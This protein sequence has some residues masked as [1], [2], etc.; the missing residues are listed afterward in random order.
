MSAIKPYVCAGSILSLPAW[1]TVFL[2]SP[3]TSLEVVLGSFA[4]VANWQHF[5]AM[6]SFMTRNPKARLG[7]Q[8]LASR[9]KCTRDVIEL[10]SDI[11]CA[12]VFMGFLFH[13]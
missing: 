5:S 3:P 9:Q 13:T 12:L 4:N 1:D 7:V 2:S 8:V 6:H 11:R 10:W